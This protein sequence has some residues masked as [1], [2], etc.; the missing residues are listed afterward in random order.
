[1]SAG[2]RCGRL[3]G[4]VA[5]DLTG[6]T[7]IGSM[8]AKAGH[9]THVLTDA[10]DI[11]ASAVCVLDT[12][13]RFDDPPTA[14]AKVHAATTALR[15][16]GY[17]RFHKKTCSVFRG[18]VGVE[19]DAMLDALS[20]EF[21]VVVLG[22]P[23]NGRTTVEG[24]HFVNGVRLEESPFRH[25]PVHPMRSSI[26][27]DI[28][29]AQTAR[30]VASL[31][32]EVVS[33]GP[34]ALADALCAERERG[35]YVVVDVVDQAALAAIAEACER[36]EVRVL[37]GASGLLEELAK[38]WP[39]PAD[40][41]VATRLEEPL[42]GSVGVLVVAGSLT[43]QT[44]TQVNHAADAGV[45]THTLDTLDVFSATAA[46][47]AVASLASL[48]ATELERGESVLIKADNRSDAVRATQAAGA[49]RGHDHAGTGR[50]V[51]QTLAQIVASCREPS[52]LSRLVVAGGDTSAAV[53]RRLG[54]TRLRVL[55]EVA[56]GVP[57]CLALAG[58]PHSDGPVTED[59]R[60]PDL[61]APEMRAAAPL[62]A[63][64]KSGSF[65][66]PGFLVEAVAHLQSAYSPGASSKTTGLE[67]TIDGS[68]KD[69]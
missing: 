31:G 42:A 9:V 30:R 7:D 14:Y 57:A 26:L 68:S 8:S 69:A 10:E 29:G 36:L 27:I 58:Q 46:E 50:L 48:A 34:V 2:N 24:V 25:D 38:L 15:I 35:G 23:K 52:G 62:V 56:P 64:F 6:A 40:R 41:G 1:M 18:N 22:F 33:E 65:G 47:R 61:R 37:C 11:P 59:L 60:A 44:L 16:T 19:F 13:S 49:E 39:A 53:C 21:A 3:L 51:S 32:H 20:E 54:I 45:A 17:E 63:V 12:D 4:V 55:G 43:P 67:V 66:G 5:D 28:L